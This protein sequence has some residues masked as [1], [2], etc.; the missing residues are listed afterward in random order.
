MA[1]LWAL[2]LLLASCGPGAAPDGRPAG[3]RSPNGG[4]MPA[5][6]YHQP[7]AAWRAAHRDL[8]R[9]DGGVE[10]FA[11]GECRLCHAPARFCNDCHRRAGIGET[12]S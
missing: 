5:P 2:G 8:T 7:L 9:P 3:G 10:P 11:S 12:G 6:A 1:L 4:R